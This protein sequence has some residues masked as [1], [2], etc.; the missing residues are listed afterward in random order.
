M[1]AAGGCGGGGDEPSTE[2]TSAFQREQ[3]RA[4][5][6]APKGASPVLRAIYRQFP[7]PEPDPQVKGSAKAIKAGEKACDGR[8]PLEVRE[9][10][11]DESNLL[12]AQAEA[13][14]ELPKYEKQEAMNESFPAGQ[15]AALVYERSLPEDKLAQFGYQGC[16]HS[17]A[18]GL[19][20]R[21]APE[22]GG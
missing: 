19:E 22:S 5:A 16:V 7:K 17:L 11:V 18:K 8:T 12:E 3:Q 13:V 2:T 10:F 9:E 15:L 20:Q 6:E 4:E 14:A 21:L 1:T